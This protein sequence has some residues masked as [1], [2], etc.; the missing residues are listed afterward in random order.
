MKKLLFKVILM[1][2]LLSLFGTVLTASAAMPV[3]EPE[4][5]LR[6][7]MAAGSW[8][9]SGCVCKRLIGTYECKT[10]CP[11]GGSTNKHFVIKNWEYR[12]GCTGATWYYS[13]NTCGSGCYYN[14]CAPL[15]P[16]S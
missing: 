13:Q 10:C 12:N 8:I 3:G 9:C 4:T 15:V 5:T 7:P 14:A 6:A 1:F 11:C 16:G 2:L